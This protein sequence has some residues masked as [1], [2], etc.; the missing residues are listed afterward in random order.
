MFLR[1]IDMLSPKIT[2]YYKQK[3]AHNS[4]I[5]GILTIIAYILI[6]VYASIFLIRYIN[7]ENPTAYF[8]NRYVED[9]GNFSFISSHFFNYIQLFNSGNAEIIDM[10]FTKLK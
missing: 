10:D 3:N 4:I 1:A 5:S 2:L 9:V 6:L 8:F 7:N